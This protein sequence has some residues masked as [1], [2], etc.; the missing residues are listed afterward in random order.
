LN[1]YLINRNFLGQIFGYILYPLKACAG[2]LVDVATDTNISLC[3][4]YVI[5]YNHCYCIKS[6]NSKRNAIP[7]NKITMSQSSIAITLY[8]G[9]WAVPRTIINWILRLRHCQLTVKQTLNPDWLSAWLIEWL[10][11]PI[12]L[13]WCVN[14]TGIIS[15][16][17]YYICRQ[18]ISVPAAG[19]Y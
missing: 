19:A 1:V 11:L 17:K 16:R 9:G 2:A 3:S 6:T 13:K 18:L 5:Q 8:V 14:F 7:L 12:S 10:I 4:F 15:H